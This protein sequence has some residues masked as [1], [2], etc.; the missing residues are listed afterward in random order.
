MLRERSQADVGV[1]GTSLASQDGRKEQYRARQF[2]FRP[3]E[4][5]PYGERMHEGMR[6]G[7]VAMTRTT[8]TGPVKKT[9]INQP[10]SS[11]VLPRRACQ[12]Q[13]TMKAF[14]TKLPASA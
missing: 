2:E 11:L 8:A 10:T 6:W 1:I 7:A 3:P 5:L 4:R 14:Q 13:A 9:L 12:Q